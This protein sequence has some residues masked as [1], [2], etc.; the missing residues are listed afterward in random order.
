MFGAG[1]IAGA[2]AMFLILVGVCWYCIRS[3]NVEDF[4][5]D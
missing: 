2:I 5:R 4:S 3:L 1:F